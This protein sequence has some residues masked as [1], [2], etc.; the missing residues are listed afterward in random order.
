MDGEIAD[1]RSHWVAGESVPLFR[2]PSR[3]AFRQTLSMLP[4]A[5]RRLKPQS[6][7]VRPGWK[8]PYCRRSYNVKRIKVVHTH[9]LH[10]VPP[11]SVLPT[12]LY[13]IPAA[14]S[15]A[16]PHSSCDIRVVHCFDLAQDAPDVRHV[17]WVRG[18]PSAVVP[19]PTILGPSTTR[20][21]RRTVVPFEGREAGGSMERDFMLHLRGCRCRLGVVFVVLPALPRPRTQSTSSPSPSSLGPHE[22]VSHADCDSQRNY[23]PRTTQAALRR[24]IHV[25]F[26][27]RARPLPI[28][29]A[30]C[31]SDCFAGTVTPSSHIFP[32]DDPLHRACASPPNAVKLDKGVLYAILRRCLAFPCS[33]VHAFNSRRKG[34]GDSCIWRVL[35]SAISSQAT[36]IW[37]VASV[38]APPRRSPSVWLEGNHFLHLSLHALG[39]LETRLAAQ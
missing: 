16:I 14:Y 29:V 26:Q 15:T 32:S 20:G 1:S 19:L 33:E 8:R 23:G 36:S 35:G 12:P 2:C 24:L 34:L 7:K 4:L 25:H 10:P 28:D 3:R 11:Q 38:A 31:V 39:A 17:A 13:Q 30:H 6:L 27:R 5:D 22:Y 37:L 18:H 9:S 21:T